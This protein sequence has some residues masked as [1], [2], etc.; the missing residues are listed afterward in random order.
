MEGLKLGASSRL[1]TGSV[2]AIP[3]RRFDPVTFRVR[4]TVKERFYSKIKVPTDP[5]GCWEWKAA[6]DKTG[7]G[8]VKFRGRTDMAHRA[9]YTVLVG[10]IPAGL[11]IDHECRNEGCVNPAHLEPVTRSE[12]TRRGY[13]PNI[14]A[15]LTSVPHGGG[16]SGKKGCKCTPCRDRFNAYRR[17]WRARKASSAH[18]EAT[19]L[20]NRE[21]VGNGRGSIP[22]LAAQ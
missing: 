16:V 3:G 21:G 12:N 8:R 5:E 22:Q 19:G 11:D 4:L 6:K 15:A 17:A 13:G 20:E 1:L 10:E 9:V 2:P 7:Y 18:G 14:S